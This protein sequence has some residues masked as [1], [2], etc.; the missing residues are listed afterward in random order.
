[1]RILIFILIL[2]IV[3]A[4]ILLNNVKC[5]IPKIISPC[6][7]INLL[8]LETSQEVV[9]DLRQ[10]GLPIY[11][12][13]SV[14]STGIICNEPNVHYGY[15]TPSVDGNKTNITISN[16]LFPYLNT[17]YNVILH[18]LLHSVGLNHNNGEQGM[19][20]YSI[21]MTNWFRSVKNDCRK[22]WISIDDVNGILK[23]CFKR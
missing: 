11:I 1:M 5:V 6:E 13:K 19:M 8:L 20:S 10:L 4:Y 7:G 12:D 21:T 3:N 22:L 23:S 17:L 9:S 15:M 16:N 14:N 2:N 18:E